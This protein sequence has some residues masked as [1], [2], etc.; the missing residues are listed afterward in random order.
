MCRYVM[1]FQF[2][3][4]TIC[5][6]LVKYTCTMCHIPTTF[7]SI[8]THRFVSIWHYLSL[9]V[10][11]CSNYTC[12]YLQGYVQAF[13]STFQWLSG[14]P[15]YV[16]F[17]RGFC[18]VASPSVASPLHRRR[19]AI[20]RRCTKRMRLAYFIWIASTRSL[21]GE[22]VEPQQRALRG[23]TMRALVC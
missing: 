10:C 23:A 12:T 14:A 2:P 18:A 16:W 5:W 8:P 13:G 9:F 4:Y 3:M 19:G 7:D 15:V 21:H 6:Y 20:S 11:I 22:E 1:V 17:L